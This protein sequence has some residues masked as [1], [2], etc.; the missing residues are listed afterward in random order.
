MWGS[1]CLESN[2]ELPATRLCAARLSRRTLKAP[3]HGTRPA[4]SRATQVAT[5]SKAARDDALA[6]AL[7]SR[8]EELLGAAL[9][10]GGLA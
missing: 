1:R 6:A 9:Q 7:W 3:F 2:A 5:P 10:K 4:L 8:T